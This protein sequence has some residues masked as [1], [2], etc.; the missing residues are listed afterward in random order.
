MSLRAPE[1]RATV[2]RLPRFWRMT[3][4]HCLDDV[5]AARPGRPEF[6]FLSERMSFDFFRMRGHLHFLTTN[7]ATQFVESLAPS[8][9]E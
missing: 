6:R 1:P 7:R 3:A 5:D 9:Q 4:T 8:H 2:H